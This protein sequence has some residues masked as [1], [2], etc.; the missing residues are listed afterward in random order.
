MFVLRRE[1]FATNYGGLLEF[2][3]GEGNVHLCF[4]EISPPLYG[5]NIA[6][7]A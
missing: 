7:T 1:H 3:V 2:F 6:D 4:V 5:T